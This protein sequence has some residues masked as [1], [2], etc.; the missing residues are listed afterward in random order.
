MATVNETIRDELVRHQIGLTRLSTQTVNEIVQLL[1]SVDDD[2]SARISR[3]S[4]TPTRRRLDE[5][6]AAIRALIAEAYSGVQPAME[7]L[8]TALA[9]KEVEYVSATI[10][11]AMPIAVSVATPDIRQLVAAVTSRPFQGRLL[12]EWAA[13]LEA[14]AFAKVRDAIRIGYAQGL[15]TA[16]IVQ[17]IRGTRATKYADGV[18]AITRRDAAAVVRTA[19][20]SIAADARDALYA[21]NSDLI[22]GVIWDATL[23]GR[24]T[25]ICQARDGKK[26]TLDGEPIGHRLPYVGGPGRAHWGCRS[27][28]VPIIKSWQELG[29]SEEEI[30]PSTRASLN[31]QVP[32]ET[33]YSDW[34]KAQ[35][36]EF[37]EDVLGKGKANLFLDGEATLEKFVDRTGATRT[38]EQVYAGLR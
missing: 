28:A 4:D 24:T 2:I 25:P 35:S 14:G 8:L 6:L 30:P 15:T 3:L 36:R 27:H 32:A 1:R 13:D 17:R 37:V 11:R 21:D 9:E 20:S 12:S 5:A 16:Q 26:Y 23:D 7:D 22:K 38:L 33:T 19:V 34:L 31:G 10:T 18:L 29:I